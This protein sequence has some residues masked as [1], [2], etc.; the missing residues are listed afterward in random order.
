MSNKK[1]A[2]KKVHRSEDDRVLGSLLRSLPLFD[3]DLYLGMQATNLEIV[4]GILRDMEAQLLAEYMEEERTPVPSAL[5]VSALSQLWIFGLY[6]LMRNWRSR[7]EAVVAFSDSLAAA[8][9]E[10]QQRLIEEQKLRIERLAEPSDGL[11]FRWP[12]FDRATR[13]A[14]YIAKVQAAFDNSELLFRRLEALRMTLAKHE[15]PKSAAYAMAPGYGRIDMLTGSI[16]WQVLLGED[17]VDIISRRELADECDHLLIDRSRYIL[18]KVLQARVKTFPKL[19]YS[20][21]HVA[22]K[23][24][25][26]EEYRKVLVFWNKLVVRVL[27]LENIPFD[28]REVISVEHDPDFP[29]PPKAER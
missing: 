6:E 28:A 2:K 20:L 25:S 1:K 19:S 9:P 22:V 4:D 29:K 10:E 24:K 27:G 13:D 23:L 16:S 8:A 26:G 3:S 7:A 15:I 5:V 18:P 12:D 11:V 21:R 14:T 17:E